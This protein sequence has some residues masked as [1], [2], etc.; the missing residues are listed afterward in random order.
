[1]DVV[2]LEHVDNLGTVGQKVK[3]KAGYARNFLLPKRLACPA[4]EQNLKHYR[5][6]IESKLRKLAKAKAA[7]QAQAEQLSALTLSFF[8]KSRDEEA[9]L[10]GSVTPMDIAAALEDKGFEIDRKQ[11]AVS[12]P[13]KKLG[14]YTAFVRLHPEVR[15][16]IAVVVR[17]E[18]ESEHG[19]GK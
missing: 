10:Y 4:T 9:R 2:L 17:P 12:E 18:E 8:R 1:M 13:I 5:T 7:A 14:E 3:V 19:A 15:A 11:I 6:L 16:E